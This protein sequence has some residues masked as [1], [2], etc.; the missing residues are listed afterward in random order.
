MEA[1]LQKIEQTA[2]HL[3]QQLGELETLSC[4]TFA[5][6][7]ALDGAVA[8]Q[9]ELEELLGEQVEDRRLD[10]AGLQIADAEESE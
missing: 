5:E 3:R 1:V 8:R 4:A 9:R 7:E 10:V 2:E 6:Q